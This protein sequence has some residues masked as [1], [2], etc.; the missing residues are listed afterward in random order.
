MPGQV[1]DVHHAFPHCAASKRLADA[2]E[3]NERRL[4][5]VH[6]FALL[7]QPPVDSPQAGVR[8]AIVAEQRGRS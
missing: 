2:N 1:E 4:A 6:D 7:H 5:A 8:A 3:L